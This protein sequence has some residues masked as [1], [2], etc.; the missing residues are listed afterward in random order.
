MAE[1]ATTRDKSPGES[2]PWLRLGGIRGFD[3]A[4]FFV[5]MEGETHL[6]LHASPI[7]SPRRWEK[8][9]EGCLRRRRTWYVP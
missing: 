4:S 8:R 6:P 3:D 7:R 5:L 9:E 1:S 2:G